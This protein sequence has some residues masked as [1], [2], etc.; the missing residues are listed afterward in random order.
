MRQYIL[1]ADD[2]IR[3]VYADNGTAELIELYGEGRLLL[4]ALASVRGVKAV[5]DLHGE[6][7]LCFSA[8]DPLLGK[9]LVLFVPKRHADHDAF[10]AELLK[11]LHL[12]ALPAEAYLPPSCDQTGRHG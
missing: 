3:L 10:R 2:T 8:E 12:S 5:R 9:Q 7:A 1:D 11:N 6:D 4:F